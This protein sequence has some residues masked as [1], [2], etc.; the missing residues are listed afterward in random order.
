MT[1]VLLRRTKETRAD[2][3]E[4]PP[5]V[6]RVRMDHL[7]K[8]EDD[9]YQSLYTQSQ[10]EF[11]NYVAAGTVLH[12][13]A[14]IFDILIRLR[15]AVDHPY[16]VEFSKRNMAGQVISSRSLRLMCSHIFPL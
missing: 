5:R 1:Q 3:I 9:Y 6:V 2:D 8:E 14:H 11:G 13:Y 15:Q 12:N 7:S 16:L 4:L 10:T